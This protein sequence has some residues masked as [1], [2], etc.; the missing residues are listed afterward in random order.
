MCL[1]TKILDIIVCIVQKKLKLREVKLYRDDTANKYWEPNPGFLIPISKLL[2]TMLYGSLLTHTHICVYIFICIYAYIYILIHQGIY[3]ICKPYIYN[4]VYV[5]TGIHSYI[6]P[7]TCIMRLMASLTPYTLW[8]QL[9]LTTV[10]F[11]LIF[12]D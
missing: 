1:F 9:P 6:F 4:S 10:F 8:F 5:C 11:F 7:A 2:N 12:L 3:R